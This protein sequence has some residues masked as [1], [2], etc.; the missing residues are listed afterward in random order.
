MPDKQSDVWTCTYCHLPYKKQAELVDGYRCPECG[1]DAIRLV[2]LVEKEREKRMKEAIVA[3]CKFT[4]EITNAHGTF[5]G[6]NI[7]FQNGDNGFYLSKSKDQTNFVTGKSAKYE[8]EEQKGAKGP[9]MKVKPFREPFVPGGGGGGG[10]S[11]RSIRS[12]VAL[13][14]AVEL[15]I[16]HPNYADSQPLDIA[17]G[18]FGWLET[19]S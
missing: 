10:K 6:F 5:Y 4:K 15:C 17:D 7:E 19:H 11:D 9:W 13:K 18:L 2:D 16:N 14:A 3:L 12:Q 1:L 8:I